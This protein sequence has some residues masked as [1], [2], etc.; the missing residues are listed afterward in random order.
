VPVTV[1]NGSV[2]VEFRV[3]GPLEV[4]DGDATVALGG[5]RQRTL[6]AILV[7]NANEVVST[8][9]LIDELW[10]ERSP[11]SGR[12]ALQVRVSQLRKALGQGGAQLLTRT[13]GYVLSLDRDQLDLQRFERLVRE[14][15]ASEP[16]AAAEKL[17]EALALWRG[18]PLADL[19]Y[20]PFAQAAIGRLDELRLGAIEKLID[21]ELALGRHGELVVELEELVAEH[22]LREHLRAQLMLAL[23]RCGRQADA[24]E[25]YRRTRVELSAELGLE[26]GRELKELESAI[27][28]QDPSLEPLS[29]ATEVAWS[30]PAPDR[31]QAVE[32][33]APRRARKVVTVLFC[34]V[35]GSTT[36]GEELDPEALFGTMNR[37]F[38]ELRAIIGRHGGTVANSIGDAVMAVFGIPQV[39]EE[40]ALRA[41]RTAAEIRTRLPA[42]AQEVGVELRFRI[43]VN[44][45]LVLVGEGENLAIGDAVNV[46]ARLQHAAQPGEI[47]LGEATHRLVRDAVEVEPLEPL[48]LDGKSEPVAA[49]RLLA[50]DPLAPGLARRF[51]VP[52]VGRERE[53]R[54]LREAW[55]RV[56]AEAGCHLFTL[57][58]AA[59]VGKSRLVAELLSTVGDDVRALQGRCLPYGEGITFWPLLEALTGAGTETEAVLERLGSG[60][61]ATPNELFLEVRL[62]LESLSRDRPV[63]LHV[64]DLQWAEQLLLDLLDHVVEL[65]R[66]AP[67]LLLCTA[68]PELLEDRPAWGGG[69]FN[70]TTMMLEPL[71]AAE[72]QALLMQLGNDLDPS[73][74]ARVISAS[75]GNPLFLQEMSAL[76]RETGGHKLPST[77]QA[78]LAARLER[79][80][81]DEREVLECGAVEGEVFHRGMARPLAG[82]KRSDAEIDELL[83]GLV[84]KDLIRPHA[85]T[86]PDDRAFRFRHLLIRDAAYD[87]LPKATRAELHE[88]LARALEVAAPDLMGLDEL[89]GWHLERAIG[90][91]RELGRE[92]SGELTE[93]ASEHLYTAGLR[94]RERCDVM[95]A[96]NLL[97][98]AR[99]LAPEADIRRARIGLDLAE[100]LIDA[101]EVDP[102]DELLTEA[103]RHPE[104]DALTALTRLELM[105]HVRPPGTT[106]AIES[107][108]PGMLEHF[109]RVGDERALARTHIL[110]CDLYWM[111]ARATPATEELRLAAEHARKAKDEGLRER[112]LA[113]YVATLRYSGLDAHTISERLDAIERE[114]PG[115]YLAAAVEMGRSAVAG[116]E[117]RADEARRLV[118]SAADRFRSL[119]NAKTVAGIEQDTGHLELSLGDPGA[120]L[121]A[122][123]R[124]D[125]ILARLGERSSRSTT[126]A[127]LAQAHWRLGSVDAALAALE[128]A[129]ELGGTEDVGTMIETHRVRAEM[130]LAGGDGEAAERWARSAVDQ[131]FATDALVDQAASKLALARVLA[132][133]E[134]PEEAVAE[135]RAALELFLTRGDRPGANQTRALLNELHDCE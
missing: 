94:A 95:A 122:L 128:L 77:I 65:S 109:S 2:S 53:L 75:E 8:D 90:Y 112:A 62:A 110:A 116:L 34:D 11:E 131:A 83:A 125:A 85:A 115:P 50:V 74:R 134:R 73:A 84:R 15:A 33:Q 1:G 30:G 120:A 32:L 126:Q 67:I 51:D 80:A 19:A 107:Q 39:H 60:G 47:L 102:V 92:V 24:L 5:V 70:A 61:T 9:R 42:L 44:T 81:G 96:T 106:R 98:R 31:E 66:H 23:Y 16:P 118:H 57:L 28:N 76:A 40:D 18:P 104:A 27:L 103:Q 130:A 133:L 117:G 58:G 68:R 93:A 59:G 21:A 10:G 127:F 100:Q 124:S 41:V 7:L 72:C 119:G 37:Y 87:S 114:R 17:R 69:K 45:G 82:G 132:G 55:A 105:T 63:L 14:A 129:E 46:A 35:T 88:R 101:G 6:L 89:A 38:E 36:L 113:S 25:V 26:P 86:L 48:S 56:V 99:L 54:L 135:A 78:L 91:R 13:P 123:Q 29:P 97:E 111:K 12:S 52:L 108:L 79:L 43:A 49:F 3:L 71:G 20:E 22:P 121:E 64:D 4:V